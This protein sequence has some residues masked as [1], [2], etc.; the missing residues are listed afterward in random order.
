MKNLV[1][2]IQVLRNIKNQQILPWPNPRLPQINAKRI[3]ISILDRILDPSSIGIYV[4]ILNPI[5]MKDLD[6]LLDDKK[7]DLEN[8]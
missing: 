4:R 6:Q 2:Q 3:W 7:K 1:N 8:L 5:F